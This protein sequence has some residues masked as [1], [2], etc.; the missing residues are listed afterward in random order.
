MAKIEYIRRQPEHVRMR[1]VMFC[2][3]VSMTFIIGIWVLSLKDSFQSMEK[4]APQAAEKG[5]ELLQTKDRSSSFSELMDRSTPLQAGAGEDKSGQNY[6]DGQLQARDSQG[7]V[8]D[9]VP[10]VTP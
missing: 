6:F 3:A 9:P 1:Y 10:A 5:K 8:S 2:L 4:L 7:T